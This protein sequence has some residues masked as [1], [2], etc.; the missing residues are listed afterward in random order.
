M[1][2]YRSLTV[3]ELRAACKARGLP[4]YQV[5][6]K[7][8]LKKDL[9]RQ[10]TAIATGRPLRCPAVPTP[11]KPSPVLEASH[12]VACGSGSATDPMAMMRAQAGHDLMVDWWTATKHASAL[13]ISRDELLEAD[14]MT[15]HR[16]L[17]GC[18]RPAD[19]RHWRT[20]EVLRG[21]VAQV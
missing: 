2:N 13:G 11:P 12:A 4:R 20:K 14:A 3:P 21:M 8:L 5:R 7:R 15:M 19:D 9:I 17:R 1:T 18:A 16:I 6:G 10:L